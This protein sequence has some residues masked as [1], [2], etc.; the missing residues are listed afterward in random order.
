[1]T[2]RRPWNK[3]KGKLLSAVLSNYSFAFFPTAPPQLI[4][5]FSPLSLS[6]CIFLPY[7]PTIGVG[8]RRQR[9][10][11]RWVTVVCRIIRY[12]DLAL[13]E[14]SY[15][16]VDCREKV[17]RNNLFVFLA[18]SKMRQFWRENNIAE[19]IFFE[20]GAGY[21]LF[22][23]RSQLSAAAKFYVSRLWLLVTWVPSVPWWSVLAWSTEEPLS[24]EG[25]NREVD[26]GER[27]EKSINSRTKS[28]V[29]VE[30]AP[31]QQP[32]WG[33]L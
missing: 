1:M 29:F 3:T 19:A 16:K 22:Y 11:I 20:I 30:M 9:S 4:P 7:I 21:G 6:W 18:S 28:L 33:V 14:S 10:L 25:A 26:G 13:V 8:K 23:P 27:Y 31:H 32:Q 17:K 12:L 24:H 2:S 5:S 15:V